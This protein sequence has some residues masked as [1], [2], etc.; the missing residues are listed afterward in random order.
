MDT[1]Y[2]MEK[3]T[4]AQSLIALAGSIAVLGLG[5]I[6]QQLRFWVNGAPQKGTP[7][8]ILVR[9]D[10]IEKDLSEIADV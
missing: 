4:L 10:K 9:L 1:G 3:V 5:F 2:I 8:A 6:T 7:D